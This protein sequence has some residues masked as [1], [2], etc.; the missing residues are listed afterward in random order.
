M[1]SYDVRPRPKLPPS[2]HS[3]DDMSDRITLL[4]GVDSSVGLHGLNPVWEATVS[5]GGFSTPF[6]LAI[7]LNDVLPSRAMMW[8]TSM[9]VAAGMKFP[10]ESM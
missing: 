2:P 1:I 10:A 3:R 7:Y 6:P 4:V 8:G 9:T 5:F